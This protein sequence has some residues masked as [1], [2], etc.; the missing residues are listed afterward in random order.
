MAQ[1]GFFGMLQKI[2][3]AVG[4]TAD[5]VGNLADAA[6]NVSK[7]AA[8]KSNVYL[9]ETTLEDEAR[10]EELKLKLAHRLQEAKANPGAIVTE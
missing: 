2:Y 5:A 10:L 1:I 7:V 9:Q 8:M 4:T 3:A 6:N